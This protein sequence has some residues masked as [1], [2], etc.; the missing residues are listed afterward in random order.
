ML[1]PAAGCLVF[2][3]IGVGFLLAEET[4][5]VVLGVATLLIFGLAFLPVVVW[6][7]VTGKPV[8][9]LD[10]GGVVLDRVAV[11]WTEVAGSARTPSAGPARS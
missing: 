3:A 1:A 7:A 5:L 8:L 11:P 6:R 10:R 9:R 2:C 4:A